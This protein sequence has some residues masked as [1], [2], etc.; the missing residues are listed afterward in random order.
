MSV[1]EPARP[2]SGTAF[3][4][5]IGRRDEGTTGKVDVFVPAGVTNVD[6]ET[7]MVPDTGRAMQQLNAGDGF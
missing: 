5:P 4:V 6:Q 7:A 2:L 1:D 3:A